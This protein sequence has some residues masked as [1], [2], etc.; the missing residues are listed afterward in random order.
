MRILA[1][2]IVV[3][4][5]LAACANPAVR[6]PDQARFDLGPAIIGPPLAVGVVAVTM[7]APSWL[8]GSAMQYRLAYAEPVRRREFADSRWA[9][10]PAELI[11]Q[12]L[13]RRFA[14][15]GGGCRLHVE[16]DEFLQV[17]EAPAQSS[18]VLAGRATLYAGTDVADRYGF[19]VARAAPTAD[20]RGG[21]TAAAE[22]V[23]AVAEELGSWLVRSE[24]CR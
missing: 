11:G 9:A 21:V 4:G 18:Q 5:W 10:P 7:E 19:L 23:A 2:L 20:A 6:R 24:R 1:I 14:G 12:A 13:E 15:R 8:A 3:S 22:A 16:L 17:F